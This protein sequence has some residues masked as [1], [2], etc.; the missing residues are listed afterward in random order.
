MKRS[1]KDAWCEKAFEPITKGAVAGCA[2]FSL[3]SRC[4]RVPYFC[5]DEEDV[6]NESILR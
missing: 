1:V 3:F 5:F 4:R 2:A 6:S